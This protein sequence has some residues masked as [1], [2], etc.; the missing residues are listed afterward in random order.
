MKSEIASPLADW[1]RLKLMYES[2]KTKWLNSLVNF[3]PDE[4]GKP[5]AHK[6]TQEGLKLYRNFSERQLYELA[7][8]NDGV[9]RI[10]LQRNNVG[11]FGGMTEV[12]DTAGDHLGITTPT[13]A[14]LHIA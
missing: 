13:Q 9:A 2:E 7:A 11:L 12:L 4:S 10:L 14:R 1:H 8:T 3:V 5:D 6:P